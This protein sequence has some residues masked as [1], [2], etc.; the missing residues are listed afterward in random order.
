MCL[1]YTMKVNVVQKQHWALTCPNKQ[2]KTSFKIS[3]TQKKEMCT[4][5]FGGMI[6]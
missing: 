4:D 1:V 3:G 5:F 2:K 6:H